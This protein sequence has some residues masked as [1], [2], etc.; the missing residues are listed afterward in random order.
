MPHD[1]QPSLFIG[2]EIAGWPFAGLEP[3]AFDVILADPP[4]D[5]KTYSPKG[6]GKSSHRHYRAM[7]LDAIKTLP[8]GLLAAN[9]CLL[10][11]WA[12]WPM[13]REALSVVDAWGFRYVTGGAWDKARMGTGYVVRSA[14]E[15]FLIATTGSFDHSRGHRNL[16]QGEAREH[17]RKPDTAY[18][19][20]ETY[21]PT[22][23]RLELFSRAS[24][25]GWAA[26]GDEAGKFDQAR[27][28]ATR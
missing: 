2:N 6:W 12:T 16:I 20:L 15:P 8:A 11:M 17:S 13:L 14:C 1:L 26:W 28:E 23:R 5:F 18:A 27:E 24:R 4:W 7:S 9:D 22:A 19:W 21:M 25:P 3:Q 10:F